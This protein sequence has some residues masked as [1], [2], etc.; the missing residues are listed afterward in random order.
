[1]LLERRTRAELDELL[2]E[3]LAYLRDPRGPRMIGA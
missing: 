3:R 2:E 1:M